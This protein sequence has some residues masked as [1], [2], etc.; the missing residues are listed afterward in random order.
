MDWDSLQ[1]NNVDTY[2]ENI[3][4]TI[5]SVAKECIPNRQITIRPSDPPWLTTEI[6]LNIR[7]RKRAYRKAKSTGFEI[8]WKKFKKMR[9]SVVNTVCKCK[10][11]FYDRLALKLKSESLSSKDW[12]STLKKSRHSNSITLYTQTTMIR[13]ILQ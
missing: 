1:D 13:R 5:L 6:K 10:K 9:N 11:A 2:S 8:D 7:K 4:S 3:T 12:W